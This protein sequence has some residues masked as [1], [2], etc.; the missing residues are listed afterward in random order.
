MSRK[1]RKPDY[2]GL[3]TMQ[4]LLNEV[5]EYFGEPVDDREREDVYHVKLCNV[6]DHFGITLIKARKLLIT[7]GKYSTWMSREVQKLSASG[8]SI[9]EIIRKT[10]LKKSSVYSYLPYNHLA[11]KLSDSSIEAERQKQYRVRKRN[12]TRTDKEKEEKLWEEMTA[13]QGCLRSMPPASQERRLVYQVIADNCIQMAAVNWCKVF[14]S[15]KSRS[16][17]APN[18]DK[19]LFQELIAARNIS[20]VD[21]CDKMR[22]FRDKYWKGAIEAEAVEEIF[23]KAIDVV[24]A[25]E[26]AA[27]EKGI[28]E[29][30]Q[31]MKEMKNQFFT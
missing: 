30:Y 3:K 7:G 6:A 25:Y 21:V 24:E 1:K 13:L 5:C 4:A 16:F 12:A 31:R 10:G 28:I 26:H 20:F 11:Y 17:Y 19:K 18:V 23:K 14:A 22:S 15:K 9:Q 29:E 27:G 8:M 2:N